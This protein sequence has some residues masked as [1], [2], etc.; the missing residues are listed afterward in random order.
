MTVRASG[1]G[2]AGGGVCGVQ[3]VAGE[4]EHPDRHPRSEAAEQQDQRSRSQLRGDL[5]GAGAVLPAPLRTEMPTLKMMTSRSLDTIIAAMNSI[6][7]RTQERGDVSGGSGEGQRGQHGRDEE[8]H[9]PDHHRRPD[10]DDR[11][12]GRRARAESVATGL[13]DAGEL[14]RGPAS[15]PALRC[16]C[17]SS[18][19]EALAEGVH[20]GDEH[21]G[22]WPTR[23]PTRGS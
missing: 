1:G 23:M 14:E 3:G 18:L 8:H 7:R 15:G 11:S 21:A 19:D 13:V 12:R 17:P 9:L 2:L 22:A 4:V 20:G 6:Q 5:T 10:D 16:S